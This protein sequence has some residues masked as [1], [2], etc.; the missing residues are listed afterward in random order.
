VFLGFV[1][2]TIATKAIATDLSVF[3]FIN[4]FPLFLQSPIAQRRFRGHLACRH[5]YGQVMDTPISFGAPIIVHRTDQS[6]AA[7]LLVVALLPRCW[8][9]PREVWLPGPDSNQRH[10]G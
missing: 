9:A 4:I 7:F 2:R 10:D 8:S 5:S 6:R 1:L 3:V